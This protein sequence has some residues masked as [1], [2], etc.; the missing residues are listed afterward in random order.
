M[1]LFSFQ[2]LAWCVAALFAGSYLFAGL[3]DPDLWWHIT[4]GRWMLAQGQIVTADHWNLFAQGQP[5]RAYSW[6]NELVLAWIELRFGLIGLLYLKMLLAA[7]LGLGLAYAFSYLA[8]DYVLGALLGLL[9][10]AGTT[11]HFTL[12]PQSLV[13]LLFALLIAASE[14]Y[15][16]AALS[17][18]RSQQRSSLALIALIMCL[19]ANS[20]LSTILGVLLVGLWIAGA[21]P[22]ARAKCA[23]RAGV[24]AL[25]ATLITPYFGAEWLTFFAKAN[26]PFVHSSIAEFQPAALNQYSTA[27]LVLLLGL[28]ALLLHRRPRAL[29]LLQLLLLGAFSLG[30]LAVVKFVPFAIILACASLAQYWASTHSRDR[31]SAAVDASDGLHIGL[32]KLRTLLLQCAASPLRAAALSVVLLLLVFGNALRALRE[33]V[34]STYVAVQAMDFFEKQ[35]LPHPLLNAFGDG[36]YVMYRFNDRQGQPRHLVPID[37]RTNVTPADVLEKHHFAFQ[38]SLRW[39]EYFDAMPQQPR[40]ILWR[41]ASPLAAILVESRDWCLVYQSP[42]EGAGH[43]L[44]VEREWWVRAWQAGQ[45]LESKNCEQAINIE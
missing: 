14:R 29:P 40:S 24:V 15:A 28:L 17:H 41:A 16:Q 18:D 27:L 38:G 32:E 19:W 45:K 21:V 31:S 33:P 23:A 2:G 43:V 25:L 34:N 20:H 7:L 13:W 26:H 37:G 5:W 10:T 12:R 36:G 3:V 8:K 9:A 30:A 4:A 35:Q 1:K 11:E 39:R 6:S 42:V 22:H 44:L